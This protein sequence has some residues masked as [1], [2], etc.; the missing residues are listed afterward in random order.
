MVGP[1]GFVFIIILSWEYI[2]PYMLS[3]NVVFLEQLCFGIKTWSILDEVFVFLQ[4]HNIDSE[5]VCDTSDFQ[6]SNGAFS[7][8]TPESHELELK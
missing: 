7:N 3:G 5:C 8:K 6:G 1:R 4:K 2:I